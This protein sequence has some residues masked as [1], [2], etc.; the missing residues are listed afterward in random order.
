VPTLPGALRIW[1]DEI[2]GRIGEFPRD[3]PIV[4]ACT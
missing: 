4:L 1:P 2:P 3:T